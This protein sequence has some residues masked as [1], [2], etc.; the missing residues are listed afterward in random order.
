MGSAT[1]TNSPGTGSAIQRRARSNRRP[2]LFRRLWGGFITNG[3]QTGLVHR[4][5]AYLAARPIDDP[6]QQFGTRPLFT[7]RVGTRL[8]RLANA[9]QPRQFRVCHTAALPKRFQIH[10]SATLSDLDNI[11]QLKM[12]KLDLANLDSVGNMR[13]W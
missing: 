4:I 9:K 13:S 7:A 10:H 5:Y 8:S 3:G 2:E 12:S 1:L 6:L 11:C